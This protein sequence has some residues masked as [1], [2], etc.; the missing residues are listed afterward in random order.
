MKSWQDSAEITLIYLL[1]YMSGPSGEVL[2]QY[3]K[4]KT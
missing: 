1:I 3:Q 2:K 4:K